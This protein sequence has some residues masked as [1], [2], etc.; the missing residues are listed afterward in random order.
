MANLLEKTN[1]ADKIYHCRSLSTVLCVSLCW[2]IILWQVFHFYDK[3]SGIW[4]PLIYMLLGTKGYIAYRGLVSVLAFAVSVWMSAKWA[5]E[6]LVL[7]PDELK[8]MAPF[9]SQLI[10][11]KWKDAICFKKG[12]TS[13]T[14]QGENI[15]ELCVW[16]KQFYVNY[17]IAEAEISHQVEQMRAV[18]ASCA[19]RSV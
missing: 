3:P 5:C 12:L 16:P 18:R 17:E 9:G 2:G 8:Y 15:E 14:I 1:R 19:T 4:S 6:R 13:W 7:T 10:S 11:V